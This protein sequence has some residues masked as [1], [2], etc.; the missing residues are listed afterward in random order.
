[1]DQEVPWQ[2]ALRLQERIVG[3]DVV[4]TLV[5]NGTHRLS[6]PLDLKRLT[7]AVSDLITAVSEIM[8]PVPPEN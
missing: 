4:V 2:T 3:H 7:E 6:E 8:V 5:K 1:M